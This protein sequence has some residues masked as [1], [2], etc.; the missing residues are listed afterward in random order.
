MI[1]VK[2]TQELDK[3]PEKYR[4]LIT[5][6]WETLMKSYED[7]V[8]D[9]EDDGYFIFVENEEDDLVDFP[10]LNAEDGGM[11]ARPWDEAVHYVDLDI[12]SLVILCNNQFGINVFIPGLGI[13]PNLKEI[14]DNEASK[15]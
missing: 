7:T 15:L 14:F 4:A 11:F 6:R 1:L 12:Y 9:P 13:D 2:H 5:K 10:H 3:I 8:F